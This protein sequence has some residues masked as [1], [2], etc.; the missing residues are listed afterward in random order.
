MGGVQVAFLAIF[1][2]EKKQKSH[3]IIIHSQLTIK[4]VAA[5]N[6]CKNS[7]KI[8]RK[9][10]ALDNFTWAS[11]LSWSRKTTFES[12]KNYLKTTVPVGFTLFSFVLQSTL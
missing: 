3:N 2:N 6:P 8:S 12:M 5:Y 11:V 10:T 9:Q 1:S 4:A 7:G